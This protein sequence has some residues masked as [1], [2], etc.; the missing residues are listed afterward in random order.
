MVP[1]PLRLATETDF[2]L[3]WFGSQEVFY[4]Q[5]ITHD[6]ILR[7][8]SQRCINRERN[9]NTLP[10]DESIHQVDC[11]GFLGLRC[12]RA[13]LLPAGGFRSPRPLLTKFSF[14]SLTCRQVFAGVRFRHV[15]VG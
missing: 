6:S 9:E 13:F 2:A 7:A 8:S 1:R 4:N 3:P 12:S 11:C 10:V 15:D 5:S 14:M